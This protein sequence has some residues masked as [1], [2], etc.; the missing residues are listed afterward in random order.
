MTRAYAIVVA[1]AARRAIERE[2][3]EK[4]AAGAIEFIF[5]ALAEDPRRVGKPLR[6][7]LLG[8]WSARRGEYRVIYAVDDERIAIEVVA[9][10]H[11]RDVYR[12]R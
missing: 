3:P 5:G 8:K 2:L 6:D 1:A 12:P 11:R 10:A 7:D 4:I 9:V